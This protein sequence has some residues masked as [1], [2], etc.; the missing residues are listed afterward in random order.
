MPI[1]T[2]NN[3]RRAIAFATPIALTAVAMRAQSRSQES[4]TAG[5]L[6]TMNHANLEK[7]THCLGRYLIDLPRDA[8]V[9]ASFVYAGGMIETR[10]KTTPLMFEQTIAARESALKSSVHKLGGSML[11]GRT[12][13]GDKKVLLQSWVDATTTQNIH[14]NESFVYIPSGSTLFVRNTESDAVAQPRTIA[15]AKMIAEYYSFRADS[16][17]PTG[18]GFCIN[19]GFIASKNPNSEEV[20]A[21]ILFK[22]FPGLS[23]SIS[24]MVTG[25]PSGSM[26]ARMER[27]MAFLD[28]SVLAAMNIL[29]KKNRAIGPVDGEE[30]LVGA[31]EN[32][33]KGYQFVWEAQG[34]ANSIEFPSVT[35]RLTTTRTVNNEMVTAP[36]KTDKE[37]LD[38]WDGLLNT[39]R[40]RTGAV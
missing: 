7:Q 26:L 37:A 4:K 31:V 13:L 27:E 36:F 22:E 20:S 2:L 16:E 15:R 17:I 32:G 35:F 5:K 25:N 38:F 33:K 21:N 14:K 34:K 3:L 9:K 24:S 28:K 6:R 23:F 30:F 19:S 8:I 18:N 12:E 39:W 1:G 29:R 40:L 11:V 10:R